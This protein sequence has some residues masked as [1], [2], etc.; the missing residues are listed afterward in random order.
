M[1]LLSSES[2]LLRTTLTIAGVIIILT[3]MG[4]AAPVLTPILLALVLAL[5]FSPVYGWL[6]GRGLASWLAIIL[7][8]VGLLVLFGALFWLMTV[9]V[10][11]LQEGLDTYAIQLDAQIAAL[12]AQLPQDLTY[13]GDGSSTPGAV[14]TGFLRTVLVG[15]ATLLG[16]AG[17]I[18]ITLL[19]FLAEG[20]ALY[21]KLRGNFVADSPEIARV[22]AFG[23]GVVTQFFLRIG[24]NTFTGVAFG[25]G[26]AI[27]GVDYAVLWGIVTFF[28]SFIPYLGITLAAIPAVLLAFAEFGAGRAIIVIIWLII[29]NTVAENLVAPAA[30]GRGLKIST[31]S[32]FIGFMFWTWLLGA[33][34]AFLAMPLTIATIL[35]L[36][37]YTETRWI[38]H[39]LMRGTPPNEAV[40][41][42]SA[43]Q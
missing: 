15:L 37:A 38:A 13:E 5:I 34:G 42:R 27:L 11:S 19:F 1:S 4:L 20:P 9:A 32:T 6:M 41:E 28:L 40:P 17:L 43:T 10:A 3:G 22:A 18:L 30:M 7:M 36:D 12:Q 31:T 24:V 8:A 29:V 39:T 2:V 25:L 23:K 35:I 16:Q 14:L 21:R 33:A 26:L